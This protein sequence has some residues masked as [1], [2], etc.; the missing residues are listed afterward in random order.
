[1][2]PFLFR[3]AGSIDATRPASAPRCDS[4]NSGRPGHYLLRAIETARQQLARETH[5]ASAGTLGQT[6][7]FTYTHTSNQKTVV[8][9]KADDLREVEGKQYLSGVTL[10]IQ[11]KDGKQYNHVTSAKA[12]TDLSSGM[13]YSEGEVEITLKVPLDQP[14]A[15][16]GK[17]MAIKSSGVHCGDQDRQKH[18]PT[19][20]RLFN[21]IAAKATLWERITILPRA[22]WKCA[23]KWSS[24][25]AARIQNRCR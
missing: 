4:G 18:P 16:S 24:S 1:M 5:R 12:E 6:H 14:S 19:G 22:S 17:L 7:S 13:L 2:S 25:G 9:V 23:A 8:T 10:D 15:P 21:S 11:D 20:W 3:Y